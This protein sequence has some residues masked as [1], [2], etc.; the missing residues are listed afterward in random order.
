MTNLK[1]IIKPAALVG[2]LLLLASGSFQSV[3]GQKG[4]APDTRRG[5]GYDYVLIE[6]D[7][8]VS[9][10]FYQRLRAAERS[11]Q[12]APVKQDTKL[13]PNGVVPF[14]FDGNVS[15]E[16]RTKM[17]DAMA[18]LEGV[19]NVDFRHCANN[20]CSGNHLHI[21][22]SDKNNSFVGMKGKGVFDWSGA[23]DINIFNWN[24]QF[25][26]VH[27]L[28]HSLGFGHEQ[29][30]S[31]RDNYVRINCG[32]IQDGCDENF[33]IMNDTTGYG[34]YDFD[35]VM[36]YG[37]CG[38]SRNASC[39]STSAEFPDGGITITVLEPNHAQWQSN[40]GQRDHLSEMD[41]VGVSFLY[42]PSGWRF[43]NIAYDGERGSSNGTFLR[44]YTNLADAVAKTPVG[45]TLWLLRTQTIPA[46]GAYGKQIT[47]KAAPGVE[48]TLGS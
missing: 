37:Q 12:L 34:R 26:I 46:V 13:W 33:K 43:F 41:R 6:G 11:P 14:E 8:Q 47:I 35:S 22:N 24:D 28:M 27:E 2:C 4:Q 18:V 48:A 15:A 36:H 16:N 19:A 38:F 40:I 20:D 31:N 45:G 10:E 17:T 32:N 25:K 7:I 21:Q 30:R 42:P 5:S 39:P 23:Q 3:N 1:K 29:S 9:P 44:P